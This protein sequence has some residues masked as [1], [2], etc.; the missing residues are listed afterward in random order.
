M[1]LLLLLRKLLSLLV[2]SDHEVAK[3]EIKHNFSFDRQNNRTGFS[4][5]NDNSDGVM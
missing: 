5:N 2:L 3:V 1:L 4:S